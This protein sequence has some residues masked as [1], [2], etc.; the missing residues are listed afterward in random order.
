MNRVGLFLGILLIAQLF[1]TLLLYR[2]DSAGAGDTDNQA[3]VSSGAYVIDELTVED[4][5][6]NSVVL[7]RTGNLW[8]LPDL[9]GLPADPEKVAKVLQQ[10]TDEDPGWTVAHTLAARQRF[11]VADYH[12]RR[13]VSLASLGQTIGTVYLGTS[14]GFRKVHA[15]N[16]RSDGIYSLDLNLYDL[17]LEAGK[18]L[19]PRL[20]QVRAPV[21]IT[22][23]G[24]SLQ[25]RDGEWRLG[26]GK[27]P[28]P[29]ELQALLDAL[30]NLQVLGVAS[31][32]QQEATTRSEATLVL[33][34]TSLAGSRKLEFFRLG[35][36]HFAASSEYPHLFRISAYDFDQLTGIDSL[37]LSGAQ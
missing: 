20:L 4:A 36:D 10:L 15:R 3:L 25:R 27:A 14:P 29:R 26:T 2:Q 9:A 16:E 32:E 13:K 21:A 11:Q 22:A 8:Q 12:F 34:I 18:W 1:L 23:D 17:P 5:N 31:Q 19:E 24:Y 30:R 33:D 28:D 7:R 37:L 35:D 6:G